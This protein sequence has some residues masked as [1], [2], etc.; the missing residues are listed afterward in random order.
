MKKFLSALLTIAMIASMLIVSASA[1]DAKVYKTYAEATKGDL[2]WQVDFSNKALFDPSGKV[3]AAEYTYTVGDN[4]NS[5]TVTGGKTDK[6][7]AV[8]GAPI[9]G[10]EVDDKSQV[11]MTFKVKANGT[12]GKNNSTGIGGWLYNATGEGFNDRFLN[13]Y[14]NWNADDGSGKLE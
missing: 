4:G 14:S 2:L 8:W 9:K 5:L 11:T 3:E 13:C 1:A 7:A 10:L 6:K 12:A